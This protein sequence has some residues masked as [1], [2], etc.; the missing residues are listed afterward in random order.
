MNNLRPFELERYFAKHEF[1]A[2]YLLCCSD[3]QPLDLHHLLSLAESETKRLWS[4]LSLAYTETQGHPL[5]RESIVD[6]FY[7]NCS[8]D[9]LIIGAPQEML[10]LTLQAL[11]K[12]GDPVVCQFPCYQSL[13]EIPAAVGCTTTLWRMRDDATFDIINDL[14]PLITDSTKMVILNVPHNPTGWLPD[15]ESWITLME[16]CKSVSAYIFSDEMYRTLE[17]GSAGHLERL[18]PVV[19]LYPEKGISLS[20][21]SKTIGLPGLR[22]GWIATR[23]RKVKERILELKDY[24]SICT[25]APSEILA[26][27]GIRA[28]DRLI[29]QQMGLLRRNLTLLYEFF[30]EWDHLLEWTPPKAGTVCFPRLLL[31]GSADDFCADAVSKAGVLLLPASVYGDERSTQQGRFRLGFGRSNL[32]ECLEQLQAYLKKDFTLPD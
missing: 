5:L 32:K 11:L 3:T 2:P 26:L 16:K 14:I 28:Y 31:G 22:V 15:K 19:E 1:E 20:G 6:T 8:P 10:A 23:E 17:F 27:I 7:H 13:L 25:A 18:P 30:S 21:V 12:S 29:D 9:D 24:S 4:E